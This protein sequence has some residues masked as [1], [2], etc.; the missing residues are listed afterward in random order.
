MWLRGGG[1]EGEG[2]GV[3]ER[4][5][6]KGKIWI[7]GG[8]RGREGGVELVRG[9]SDICEGKRRSQWVWLVAQVTSP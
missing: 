7:L 5:S 4:V 1:S 3:F 9:G 6:W 8:V 2:G